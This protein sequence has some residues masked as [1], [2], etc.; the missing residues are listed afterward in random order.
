MTI[1]SVVVLLVVVA[2][3]PGVTRQDTKVSGREV[4][5][6]DAAKL[7]T[8]LRG[9]VVNGGLRFDDP[10]C[11]REFGTPGEIKPDRFGAFA[12]CL[13]SL[14]LE[15]SARED[16]LGDVVVMEH[17]PGFELQA[18]VVNENDG[19]RLTWI[20][21]ASRFEGDPEVPTITHAALERLRLAGDRNPPLDP[22]VASTLE[23]DDTVPER[24]AAYSWFKVCLDASGAITK[25]DLFTTTGPQSSKAFAAAIATWKFRPFVM[26]GQPLP[27]CALVRMAYP[28]DKAPLVETL[29]LPPSPSRSKKRPLVLASPTLLEGKR[30]AGEKAIVPDDVTKYAIQESGLSKIVGTFR[31]CLDDTGVVESVLPMKTTGFARYDARL[32][33]AMKQ[34]RYSPYLVDDQPVPVCT[35]VTFI[36]S[37]SGKPVKVVR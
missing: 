5:A 32:I 1:R 18:R 31:V 33:A 17:A 30:L 2:C 27:V 35:A 8:V 25:A 26:R 29:P 12:R 10:T 3:G 21:F 36:Y 7:E 9:S 28:A 24:R 20:G 19:P 37:Q 22:E 23:L 4:L 6:G 13:A 15:P 11:A 16:S 34:W 14:K